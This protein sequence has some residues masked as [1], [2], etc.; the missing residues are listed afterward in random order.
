MN[1]DEFQLYSNFIGINDISIEN[2]LSSL[3]YILEKHV[4]NIPYR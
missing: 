3:N 4:E 1:A 2:N